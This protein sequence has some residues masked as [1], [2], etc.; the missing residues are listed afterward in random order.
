MI[1][2]AGYNAAHELAKAKIPTALVSRE[3]MFDDQQARAERFA[4]AGHAIVLND[5]SAD[6]LRQA[7]TAL[8][9]L[10]CPGLPP[11]GARMAAREIL[12]LVEGA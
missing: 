1:S 10:R 2:A 8:R 4:R 6:S 5:T 7:M 11:D 9:A 3:R 12:T